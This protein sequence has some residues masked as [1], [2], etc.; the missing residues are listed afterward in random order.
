MSR[1]KRVR[2][3]SGGIST[4]AYR[5]ITRAFSVVQ[6]LFGNSDES[7]DLAKYANETIAIPKSPNPPIAAR[8]ARGNRQAFV[9][10]NSV[11][12]CAM[13]QGCSLAIAKSGQDLKQKISFVPLPA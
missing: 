7:M 13:N 4:M 5:T 2:T 6:L 11:S 1:F 3:T 12:S 8:F 9:F 10:A